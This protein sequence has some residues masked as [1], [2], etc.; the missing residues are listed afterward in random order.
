MAL[1]VFLFVV[2]IAVVAAACNQTGRLESQPAG[3]AV[4]IT[5]PVQIPAP[6]G[7]PPVPIPVDNQPTAETIALGR[8]LFYDPTLS[9]DNTIACASLSCPC[10]WV[11]RRQAGI[12]GCERTEGRAECSH[13]FQRRLFHHAILGRAFTQPGRSGRGAPTKPN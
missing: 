7:L 13:Y 4:P 9:V 12:G 2:L 1:K 8:K 6:L 11:Y 10:L 3:A 5:A